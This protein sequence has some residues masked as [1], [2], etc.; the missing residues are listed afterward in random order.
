MCD[1]R[2]STSVYLQANSNIP[3]QSANTKTFGKQQGEQDPADV[4]L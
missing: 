3:S 4:D 2:N 1:V